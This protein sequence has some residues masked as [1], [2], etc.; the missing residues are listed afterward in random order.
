MVLALWVANRIDL[1]NGFPSFLLGYLAMSAVYVVAVY[2]VLHHTHRAHNCRGLLVWTVV[3]AIALRAIFLFTPP[4]LSDDIYRYVWD[5]RVQKNGLNPYAHAPAA[6]Q[7]EHLRDPTYESINNKELPTIYPPMMQVVLLAVATLSESVLG[8][9]AAFVLI[10][11]AL[12]AI[13]VILLTAANHSPLRALIYA[14]SPLTIVEIAGSGHNDVLMMAFLM[15]GHAAVLLKK[16]MLSICLVTLAGHAKL[17]AFALL[18]FFVRCTRPLAWL[19][20]PLASLILLFP[21]RGVTPESFDGLFAYGLR[22]R[23]NDSLFHV[24]YSLTGSL[25][26]SKLIAGAAVAALIGGLLY[27][28][29][30]P[31]RASYLTIGTIL[32]L[33]PTV[34]PWYVMWLVPY[35]C[36]FPSPA[37]LLLT[38]TIALSYH[39]PFLASPGEPWKE[40]TGFKVLEYAPFFLLAGWSAFSRKHDIVSGS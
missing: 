11:V 6:P 30:P 40:L 8:M 36:F 13:L 12:I 1:Q 20:I 32:L 27:R 23:A 2:Y 3:V 17:M 24:L 26:F 9:K 25:D 19:A 10:D 35:L 16:D 18:P 7:L 38:A 5:G 29:V 14:W 4:A 31:L 33:S 22:W 15:A 28:R 21:Y 34:H 39:A 37:W